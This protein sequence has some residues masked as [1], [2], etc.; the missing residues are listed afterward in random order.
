ML[1]SAAS[2]RKDENHHDSHSVRDYYKEIQNDNDTAGR[3]LL[4]ENHEESLEE[5]VTHNTDHD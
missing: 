5:L 1:G 3:V 4:N 2:L